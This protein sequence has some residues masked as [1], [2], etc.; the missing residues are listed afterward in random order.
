MIAG[1]IRIWHPVMLGGGHW[2]VAINWV[3]DTFC[4][5]T[6]TTRDNPPGTITNRAYTARREELHAVKGFTP[7]PPRAPSPMEARGG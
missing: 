6:P 5:V 7:T 3:G 4:S 1:D 2:R